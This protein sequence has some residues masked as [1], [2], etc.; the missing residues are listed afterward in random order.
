[1]VDGPPRALVEELLTRWKLTKLRIVIVEGSSDQRLLRLIQRESHCS[2]TLRD[3]DVWGVDSID[4]PAACIQKHGLGGTGAKQRVVAFAREVESAALQDGFRGLVDK[5]L[6]QFVGINLQSASLIYTDHGCMEAY[7]WTTEVLQRL[8]IQFKCEGNV[9]NTREVKALFDSVVD[10]C[11]DIA[12]VR[13][14]SAQHPEWNMTL[15]HSDKALNVQKTKI[16]VDL[17]KYVEQCQPIKGSL[18][19]AKALVTDVRSELDELFPMNVLNG[20]DLL[21]VLVY[22]LRAFTSSTRRSV[23]E[24]TVASSMVAFG[25]MNDELTNAPM[26]RSLVEWVSPSGE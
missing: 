6:D 17:M 8:V 3:L 22:A 11:A 15:H 26:F 1:M 5:D 13:I 18:D 16:T 25:V 23:D 12:A 9:R 21:W 20:H 19:A 2:K 4:V 7:L 10:S 14:A 24:D